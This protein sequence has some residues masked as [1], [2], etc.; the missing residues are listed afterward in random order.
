MSVKE[1]PDEGRDRISRNAEGAKR[2]DCKRDNRPQG[3]APLTPE[4]YSQ[5]SH[6]VLR[7]P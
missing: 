6:F 3:I 5:L 2:D 1:V 4:L 7:V